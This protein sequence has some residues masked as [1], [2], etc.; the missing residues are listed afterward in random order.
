M[1]LDIHPQLVNIDCGQQPKGCNGSI[2]N[3]TSSSVVNNKQSSDFFEPNLQDFQPPSYISPTITPYLLNQ[4]L[5]QRLLVLSGDINIDK[6]GLVRH[7]A[8]YLR[9]ELQKRS[10]HQL[11]I[12]IK[13]WYRSLDL[14]SDPAQILSTEIQ[15]TPTT[16]IYILT[17]TL[18]QHVNYNLFQLQKS[19]DLSNSY[20]L[21]STDVP[22][23]SWN[24]GKTESKF[25]SDLLT[26][27]LEDI[28]QNNQKILK[29]WFHNELQPREQ[30]LAL[31]LNFFDGLFDDQCMAGIWKLVEHEWHRRDQSL[32][33]LDYCDFHN[34][35]TFFR[36]VEIPEQKA[37]KFESKL[38]FQ[39]KTL[40]EV[41]WDSY[42]VR[43]QTA[44][45]V[46]VE[47]VKSSVGK[48]Y[49]AQKVYG[50]PVEQNLFGSELR[51]NQL[52]AVIG[53]AISDI[54]LIDSREV[55]ETL[56]ALA[57]HSNLGVQAVAAFAIAR[58]REYGYDKQMFDTLNYW[59]VQA[60]KKGE[61][62]DNIL[63]TIALTIGYAAKD[64]VPQKG[65]GG[66]TPE[67]YDLLKEL[68]HH[69][70][71]LVCT[72]LGQWTLKMLVPL[73]LEQLRDLL[74]D[75]TQNTNLVRWISESLALAAGKNSELVFSILDSWHQESSDRQCAALLATVAL[76]CV[77][78]IC[79][80]KIDELTL[81]QAFT[82]LQVIIKEEQ[83]FWEYQT[84]VKEICHHINSKNFVQI[85]PKLKEL[86]A[87]V[88]VAESNEIIKT[89][90]KIYS[91]QKKAGVTTVTKCSQLPLWISQEQPTAM[92]EA[93]LRWLKSEDKPAAQIIGAKLALGE[94]LNFSSPQ[95]VLKTL[96]I[97]YEKCKTDY[98][99]EYEVLLTAVGLIAIEILCDSRTKTAS[100]TEEARNYLHK[101]LSQETLLF[102]RR[103]IVNAICHQPEQRLLQ[104]ERHLKSLFPNFS[105][106][107]L[108]QIIA[109]LERAKNNSQPQE[110]SNKKLSFS[111]KS[112]ENE[113]ITPTQTQPAV[114][115]VIVP[116]PEKSLNQKK[117]AINIGRKNYVLYY[118]TL[119]LVLLIS[120]T[121]SL[122]SL[123]SYLM[124]SF[125]R[126]SITPTQQP[127]PSSR[128]EPTYNTPEV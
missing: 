30:L 127:L 21:I 97:W 74:H 53:E 120:V 89:L 115:R 60:E 63:C 34:L 2:P 13:E 110:E 79:N 81:N 11:S 109:A 117:S 33:G 113:T 17:H 128:L 92:E 10:P 125:I 51:R 67:L 108:K 62:S 42:R 78:I 65:D 1:A 23:T 84:I 29:Q 96:K 7:L 82:H 57:S 61:K 83:H 47:L 64:D 32:V 126:N 112:N 80:P 28:A 103:S 69:P 66:L 90:V 37:K 19:A 107:E 56:L 43:I 87:W 27:D 39:R 68:S 73:H 48:K 12:P 46:M 101:I 40:F 35:Q 49:E 54:G 36:L 38:S 72:R 5:E 91:Q 58:W 93:M 24:L 104:M 111:T 76:T 119:P 41:A 71:K 55:Q 105:A 77:Y 25:W 45:P 122:L 98:P 75:M 14:Y 116:T 9:S 31:G 94:E 22:R 124:A 15:S 85:E 114:E 99:P 123:S 70:S 8:W 50:I 121:V 88:S 86:V 18:P 26:E 44:L 118:K 95:D 3:D 59:K 16:T 102:V 100:T 106:D 20:V 6:V 4:V 52:R